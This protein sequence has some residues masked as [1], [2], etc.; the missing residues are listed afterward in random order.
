MSLIQAT[1]MRKI[2]TRP[3]TGR[4]ATEPLA[5]FQMSLLDRAHQQA[6]VAALGQAALTG[7][8]LPTLIEQ[9]AIFV[10]QTLSLDFSG[11]YELG[12]DLVTLRMVAGHGWNSGVVGAAVW[13][14]PG[15]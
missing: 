8:D 9:A 10:A 13:A 4:A 3:V 5:A 11:I 7:V 2:R 6:A 15:S 12:D 14:D 1:S